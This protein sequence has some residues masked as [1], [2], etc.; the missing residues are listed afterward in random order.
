M[1]KVTAQQYADK[2]GRRL[3]GAT[4]DIRQGV[5][6]VSTAPGQKAASQADKMLA[7]IQAAISDGKWQRAVGAVTLEEWKDATLQKGIGRISSGVDSSLQSQVQMAEK[8]LAAVDSVK[9]Q[10]DNMPDTTLDDRINR[11]VAFS[12]G[13]S[14]KKIK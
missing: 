8:L 10:V 5:E 14:E 3:K 1:A 9:S 7:G 13:M 11:M 6:R 2:W 12:R 4:T